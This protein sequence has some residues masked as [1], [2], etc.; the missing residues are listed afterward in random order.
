[1]NKRT[2]LKTLG[3]GGAAIA[4]GMGGSLLTGCCSSKKEEESSDLFV[5]NWVWMRINSN[6]SDADYKKRFQTLKANGISGVMFEQDSERHF[7]LAKECGLEAHRWKWTMNRGEKFIMENHPEWYAVNRKGESS[8]DKP[9][10]VSYYRFCCPNNEEFVKYL[11]EDYK[12]EA[13]KPYVD[14]IHLDYVRYP[15]VIL[16]VK[17][18]ENYGI[19]QTHEMPEYDYCYCETCRRKYRELK[20]VDPLDL[21]FPMESQSWIQFRLDAVTKAVA[22][23]TEE[24]HKMG[25][26]ISGAV[27]PGPSM[28]KRMVRQDWGNWNLDAY[29]PMIYNGFYNEDVDWIGVSTRESVKAL[30]G[31]AKLYSGLFFP[32]IKNKFEEAIDHAFK[33]GASGIAFFDGPDDQSLEI[34]SNYLAKNNLKVK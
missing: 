28:A 6:I 2:F 27:F 31:Q 10:Y 19:E 3:L 9:A 15:D 24:I 1:M 23:I 11:I 14:G 30:Q 20:G 26:P 34:F 7:T 18:W 12:K 17:L 33:A 29:F 8:W 21:K 16:P 22:Q 4:S 25:K 13:S 32:D 5:K